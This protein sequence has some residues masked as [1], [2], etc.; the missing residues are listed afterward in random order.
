M[1]EIADLSRTMP[2][3]DRYADR[4][5][6]TADH[7]HVA[8]DSDAGLVKALDGVRL[9]VARGET[10]ALVG[11]SGCG[12]SMTA[13]ALM[14]L[15]P[16]NG[17]IDEGS[18]LLDDEELLALPEA[19]MRERR[20]GKIGIIFQDP[21]TSLNPVLKVGEQIVETIETHTALRGDAARAKAIDWLRLVGIPEP[22]ASHRQ[23]SVPDVGRPE[24]ARDDRDRARGRARDADRRRADDRARR[25]DPGADPRPA[26]ATCR[27]GSAWRSC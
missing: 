8:L 23:L 6:L 2:P 12:K 20:G 13:M 24:A 25:H 15:L 5:I 17:R 9:S 18:V 16:D 4:E 10:F 1:R 3:G 27:S 14:R 21:S 22:G 19:R 11:E 7:L 26:E